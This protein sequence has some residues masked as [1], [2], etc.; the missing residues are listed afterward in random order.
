MFARCCNDCRADHG[1]H[2]LLRR[3][4]VATLLEDVLR[5]ASRRLLHRYT[6]LHRASFACDV[7]TVGLLLD[8][9]ARAD[10]RTAWGGTPLTLALL[11]DRSAG[12]WRTETAARLLEVRRSP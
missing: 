5:K 8:A 3:C 11:F 9:G 4:Q 10:V 6:A 7:G 12:P 1:A 2:S